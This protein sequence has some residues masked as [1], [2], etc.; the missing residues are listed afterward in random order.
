MRVLVTGAKGQLGQDVMEELNSRKIACLGIDRDDY[1]IA[2]YHQVQEVFLHYQ[3][4]AVIHCAAFTA[5]DL[6][7]TKKEECFA[8]NVTGSR[9][10]ASACLECGA[11]I[12]ALSTDYVFGGEGEDYFEV[13]DPKNPQN[14]YGETKLLA[15][16]AIIEET[17]KHFIVRTSWVFGEKGNNFVKT[18]RRLAQEQNELKVVKDETGSPTYTK[19]LAKLLVDM[20]KTT[21]YGV[22]HAT[23]EGICNRVE[24]VEEILK[25][26]DLK[27]KIIPV[28]HEEFPT[29]AIRPHNS[30]LSKKS[31]DE[32][33]FAR[34]PDWRDALQ[35]FECG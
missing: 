17:N 11:S 14:Y 24:F 12:V 2:D 31:L 32:A 18:I 16:K 5:V 9:Y 19:D 6:A 28:S 1:D 25:R 34:L 29:P 8:A 15:E 33:G 3:P 35:R 22:Y 27:C 7:E 30:R 26:F 4:T 23:N 21:K 13:D 20:I 10:I